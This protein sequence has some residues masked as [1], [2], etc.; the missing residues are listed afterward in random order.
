[1]TELFQNISPLQKVSSSKY[2]THGVWIIEDNY[3]SS[4]P[5]DVT[6]NQESSASVTLKC[7]GNA[8]PFKEAG[9][10]A[11]INGSVGSST[12]Y[13]TGT[14]IKAYTKVGKFAY[15]LWGKESWQGTRYYDYYNMWNPKQTKKSFKVLTYNKQDVLERGYKSWDAYNRNKNNSSRAPQAPTQKSFF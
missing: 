4:S 15:V 7:S 10:S 13:T 3:N 1:M 2:L 9:I 12:S 14:P 11:G 8:T 5:Y 6:T